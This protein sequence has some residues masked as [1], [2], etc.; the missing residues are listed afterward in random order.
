MKKIFY[1]FPIYASFVKNDEA[2]LMQHFVVKSFHFHQQKNKII[3]SFIKQFFTLLMKCWST[4]MYLSFFAGYSSWLPGIFAKLSGKPHLI[5][6]G[7][8]DCCAFPSFGYGNFQ[9][10]IMSRFTSASLKMAA[11]LIPVDQS[12]VESENSFVK[13][14]Y[15]K[16]GY[17]IFC[18]DAKA[19][20]TVINIGYDPEKFYCSQKK[21]KNS[22]LTMAQMNWANYYRKGIDLMFEMANRFPDCSFTLV[23]HNPAMQFESVPENLELIPFVPYEQIKDLYSAHEFYLQLSIMEGFPSAPC[24]AM[25]CEC[26][27]IVSNV[28]ALPDIVGD[29]GFT[30]DKKDFDL[31]EQLIKTALQSDREKLRIKARE[32]IIS[33]YP[34]NL[35]EKLVELINT[36]S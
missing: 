9:K 21:N 35:R 1:S 26:I 28:A 7:G 31:L 3:F 23:G 32:R 2:L 25:L 11:H 33:K 10:K 20:V 34:K 5:I 13:E 27:P 29:A 30:L 17:K 24:E 18:P 4:D 22:F 19:P 16:Q 12:L 6:L 15:P 36:N 14:I 8:T